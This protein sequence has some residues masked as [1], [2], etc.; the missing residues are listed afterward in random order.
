MFEV[1]W[2]LLF[3]SL[4]LFIYFFFLLVSSLFFAVAN[5]QTVLSVSFLFPQFGKKSHPE[6]SRFSPDGQYLV[7]CSVDGFIE[8]QFLLLA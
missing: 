1:F 4:H 8:V 2:G 7:S 6:C 3:S 5:Y